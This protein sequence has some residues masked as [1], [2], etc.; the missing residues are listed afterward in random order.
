MIPLERS[1]V[2]IVAVLLVVYL[3]GLIVVYT[4]L[5]HGPI[6]AISAGLVVVLIL[7]GNAVIS[8]RYAACYWILMVSLI[9]AARG[10]F[11]NTLT[12]IMAMA[13]NIVIYEQ[14]SR[15][16]LPKRYVQVLLY[17]I[18]I[19]ALGYA[20]IAS[21]W[22]KLFFGNRNGVPVLLVFTLFMADSYLRDDWL[23]RTLVL[24]F[25]LVFGYICK[26]RAGFLAIASYLLFRS[27]KEKALQIIIF[28]GILTCLVLVYGTGTLVLPDVQIY[29]RNI[30]YL[31]GRDELWAASLEI[32]KRNPLGLGY[33]GYSEIYGSML[34]TSLSTHNLYLNVLMQY[35]WFYAGT[36]IVLL[37]LLMS[38]A[39][40]PAALAAV[41]AMHLRGFF[42]SGIPF[43]LSLSSAMLLL[44]FYMEKQSGDLALKEAPEKKSSLCERL[45]LQPVV[46][47]SGTLSRESP[48][49]R[50]AGLE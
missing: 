12:V 24:A 4:S 11:V 36:Y 6:I 2:D 50:T 26:S 42:E 14:F 13:A 5:G 39:S 10:E 19:S 41:L 43:G 16:G 27:I 3:V 49:E 32:A 20:F 44:P 35:G 28:S 7:T 30:R 45:V 8:K 25:A 15:R 33:G 46:R 31:A 48:C 40:N 9:V 38:A 34:G 18:M 23:T 21:S 47:D 22:D 1:T 37:V 17:M 29:G